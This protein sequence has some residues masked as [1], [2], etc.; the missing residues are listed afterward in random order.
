MQQQSRGS[1]KECLGVFQ[2]QD[3]S[4]QDSVAELE[5]TGIQNW[6]NLLFYGNEFPSPSD[7]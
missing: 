6:D 4:A 3:N 5:L 1:G 7:D 2:T